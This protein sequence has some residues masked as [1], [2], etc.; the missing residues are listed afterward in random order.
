MTEGLDVGFSGV[1][2]G[3]G[4]GGGGRKSDC[5]LLVERREYA[6]EDRGVEFFLPSVSAVGW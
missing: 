1:F 4:E 3:G 6:F 5:L 2:P